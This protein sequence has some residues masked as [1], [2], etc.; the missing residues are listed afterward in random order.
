MKIFSASQIKACDAY[1]IHA[2][3]I[4]SLE[5]MER[6]A[7]ACVKWIAEFLPSD[8]LFIV[9]C[10]PGNNGGDG[11]A[12]TRLLHRQGYGAKAFLLN[13]TDE[14]SPDCEKNL[15][16]LQ[17]IDDDL[18]DILEEDMYVTDVPEHVYIIDAILGTGINRAVEGW[19][20]NFISHINELPNFKVAV[21]VP[22]GMPID[23][24]PDEEVQMVKVDHT[25]SFQFYKRAFLHPETGANT[26]YVH[27]LDIG[28]H[29]TFIASTHT[30]YQTIDSTT[31]ADIYKQRDLFT[32]KGDYGHALIVAGSY[33]MM[34]AAVLATKAAMRTGAGKVTALIPECGYNILQSGMP[35]VM[36]KACGDKYISKVSSWEDMDVVG[37]GPGLSTNENAAR[38]VSEFITACK[39]PI[40]VDADALNIM[41]ERKE[42]LGKLPT[43][44]ILTPH[45]KEF[46]R[47]FGESKNSMQRLEK[48]RTQAMRY[49]IIIVLKGRCTTIVT[50]EGECWYNLT[51]NP[52]MATAGSGD[53]LTGIIT[54]LVA[55]GYT[56]EDAAKLGVYIHGLAGNFAAQKLSQE[57]MIAG[58]I[59]DR[60][61]KA[62]KTISNH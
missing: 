62:F 45:P 56:P 36:C 16:R 7:D 55:Q 5:L 3:G 19:V 12:I 42:L 54:G 47:L 61:G 26:G 48:A 53:V 27:L 30:S 43:D 6:A 33:G 37:I 8:A 22:S 34:G 24:I 39:D 52:G 17:N 57:A 44:S 51:G 29:P 25:L 11:L 14:L 2:A 35:E 9:L 59:I 41:A 60:L 20:A 50:P 58:D 38:A 46:D 49:N 40:V 13:F 23:N 18:V 15:E 21:D 1:T 28:L 4:Q 32:H 10:G 31:I